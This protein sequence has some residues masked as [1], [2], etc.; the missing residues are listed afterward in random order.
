MEMSP[1]QLKEIKKQLLEQIN[2]TFPEDKKQ[3]AIGQMEN[4][5]DEQLIEF[6]KQNNLL[7]NGKEEG[8]GSCVFCSIIFGEIPSTKIAENEK[9]IAILEI[10]PI[11]EGHT[12]IIPKNHLEKQE[13]LDQQT[14]ALAEQIKEIL[15]RALNPKEINLIPGEVMGHQIINVL[16]VYG[17]E[18]IESQRTKKTPEDLQKLKEKIIELSK[19]GK[20][21]E[22]EIKQEIK[23]ESKTEINEKNMWLPKRIP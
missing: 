3:E 21:P 18:T 19:I 1:E 15:Q 5:D 14:K 6:L 20:S 12:I 23:Q 16:P 17:G 11:S 7:K 13:D 10:N 9:A 4:M 8:N 2:T 22:K